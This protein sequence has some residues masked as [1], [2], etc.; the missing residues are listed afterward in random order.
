MP[1]VQRFY[2]HWKPQYF[3]SPVQ[4]GDSRAVLE[5]KDWLL[6][7]SETADSYPGTE[8]A[9]FTRV[10]FREDKVIRLLFAPNDSLRFQEQS[11][12]GQ[13]LGLWMKDWEK[14]LGLLPYSEPKLAN[15]ALDWCGLVF[16]DGLVQAFL[17]GRQF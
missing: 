5:Q 15:G 10:A 6:P 14:N 7:P 16:V 4:L 9:P 8:A 2:Y 3:N 17:V 11:L 13:S 1:H 12:W